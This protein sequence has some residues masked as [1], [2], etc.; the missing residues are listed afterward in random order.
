MSMRFRHNDQ[1]HNLKIF[2][3]RFL[4]FPLRIINQ[5]Q[6]ELWGRSY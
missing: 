1:G 5:E 2:R 4:I 6:D 3:P